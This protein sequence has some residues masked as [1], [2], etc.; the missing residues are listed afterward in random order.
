MKKQKINN[1]AVWILI[2][3]F[4]AFPALWYS[5][6]FMGSLW[7]KVRSYTMDNF[8]SGEDMGGII[9]SVIGAIIFNYFLA[10]LFIKLKVE[11][12][13][14][15]LKITFLLFLGCFFF[16][17]LTQNSFSL[18]PVELGLINGGVELILFLAAGL[19]LSLWRKYNN[20]IVKQ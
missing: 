16:I 2:V 19:L 11:T 14:E 1:A 17:T 3:F 20:K 7:M 6:F 15:G 12:A 8:K 4:Q 13:L 9:F 18:R 5:P 10:W